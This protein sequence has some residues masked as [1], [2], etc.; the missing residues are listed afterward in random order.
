MRT[1]KNIVAT[2]A[3]TRCNIGS[4]ATGDEFEIAT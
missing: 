4:G 1:Y 2:L 3:G